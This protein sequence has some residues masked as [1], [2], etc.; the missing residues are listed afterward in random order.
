MRRALMFPPVCDLCVIGF[1]GVFEEKVRIAAERFTVILR[2]TVSRMEL[3]LP[4]RVLGPVEAGYGRLNGKFRRRLL[5]K[6]KNT[7]EMRRFIRALLEQAY[8]DKAFSGISVFAD[9]N[10]DCGV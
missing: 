6:C 2:E 3:K 5:L 1:A 10:G 8:A 7:A 4:L 9:M